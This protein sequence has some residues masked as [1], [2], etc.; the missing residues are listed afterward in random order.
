VQTAPQL[1]PLYD[2]AAAPFRCRVFLIPQTQDRPF[3]ITLR[4]KSNSSSNISFDTFD[5]KHSI[6]TSLFDADRVSSSPLTFATAPELLPRFSISPLFFDGIDPAQF[7]PT[8]LFDA[9]GQLLGLCNFGVFCFDP[10]RDLVTLAASFHALFGMSLVPFRTRLYAFGGE[11]RGVLSDRLLVFAPSDRFCNFVYDLRQPANFSPEPRACHSAAVFGAAMYIFG[12]R[13]AYGVVNDLLRFDFETDEF[14]TLPCEE[15]LPREGHAAVVV[16]PCMVIVGGGQPVQIVDLRSF[17]VT[18]FQEGQC[19]PNP[20]ARFA[21]FLLGER[22]FAIGGVEDEAPTNS[23]SALS[24]PPFVL[25]RRRSC[26][27]LRPPIRAVSAAQAARTAA[28][29]ALFDAADI[30]TLDPPHLISFRDLRTIDVCEAIPPISA[31][32]VQLPADE[33]PHPI[34]ASQSEL[35]A[36]E[37]APSATLI[38]VGSVEMRAEEATA[39]ISMPISSPKMEFT[40]EEATPSEIAHSEPISAGKVEARAEE[41]APSISASKLQSKAVLGAQRPPVMH[42]AEEIARKM[43]EKDIVEARLREFADK[44]RKEKAMREKAAGEELMRK[45]VAQKAAKKAM[46]E[47]GGI[48]SFFKKWV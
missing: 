17:R 28:S 40:A 7:I 15:L 10:L 12:G 8:S 30:P 46:E 18:T 16:G 1:P 6:P 44:Q 27:A 45:L 43:R 41:A 3:Y 21:T 42:N 48:F 34:S 37:A 11:S 35:I 39:A 19:I 47:K 2:I 9:A 23:L 32:M 13:T 38:S 5:L 36:E 25:G 22:I 14:E 20:T 4:I 29:L 31:P 26:P 33:A 24:L